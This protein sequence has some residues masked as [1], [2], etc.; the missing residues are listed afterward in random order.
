VP[1]SSITS[2]K[3]VAGAVGPSALAVGVMTASDIS[4]NF[5][6]ASQGLTVSNLVASAASTDY[7]NSTVAG[8]FTNGANPLTV[9][10]QT[11]PGAG[12]V[13]TLGRNNTTDH[14][15]VVLCYPGGGGVTT[16]G[17]WRYGL[18]ESDGNNDLVLAAISLNN[19]VNVDDYIRI[20]TNGSIGLGG[21]G[22]SIRTSGAGVNC[23]SQ[24]GDATTLLAYDSPNNSYSYAIALQVPPF[25]AY[26][27]TMNWIAFRTAPGITMYRLGS[28]LQGTGA[29]DFGLY[30]NINGTVMF[31]YTT[32]GVFNFGGNTISNANLTSVSGMVSS[33]TGPGMTNI[34]GAVTISSAFVF[35]GSSNLWWAI[36]GT[37]TNHQYYNSSSISGGTGSL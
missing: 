35:S 33:V 10:P 2:N 30:N 37:T 29:N 1:D 16:N 4:N 11:L 25:N 12:Q 3:I 18:D 7:V 32:N 21:G 14:V 9:G 26:S 15:A 24:G 22:A 6:T 23:Y 13:I 36:T 27:P 8:A 5:V 31:D 28:D 17:Q 19:A 34:N 20:A